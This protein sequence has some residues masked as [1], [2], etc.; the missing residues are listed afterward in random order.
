MAA[1][2]A[3]FVRLATTQT[4]FLLTE[5]VFDDL[6][7]SLFGNMRVKARKFYVMAN[8]RAVR[9]DIRTLWVK[10]DPELIEIIQTIW[11][12]EIKLGIRSEDDR[13]LAG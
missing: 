7:E 8:L 6:T 12:L 9:E 2:I 13:R 3:R 10:R 11:K 1:T 4:V 5:S